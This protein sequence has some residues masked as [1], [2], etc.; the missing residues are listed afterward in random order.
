MI[1]MRGARDRLS[2]GVGK[3]LPTKSD[4]GALAVSHYIIE[5]VGPLSTASFN[6]RTTSLANIQMVCSRDTYRVE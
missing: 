3:G 1:M 2:Q 5:A 6:G 4:K